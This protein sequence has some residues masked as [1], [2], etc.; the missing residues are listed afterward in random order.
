MLTPNPQT[1]VGGEVVPA[2]GAREPAPSSRD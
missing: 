1:Q 2:T